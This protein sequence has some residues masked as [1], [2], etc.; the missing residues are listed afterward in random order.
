[1]RNAPGYVVPLR[2]TPNN[3]SAAGGVGGCGIFSEVG[4]AENALRPWKPAFIEFSKVVFGATQSPGM[5]RHGPARAG[6]S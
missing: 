5:I 2:E 1:M 6:F 3:T 4:A